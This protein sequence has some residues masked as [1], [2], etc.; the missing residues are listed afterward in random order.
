MGI[1]AQQTVID[2]LYRIQKAS[3][4]TATQSGKDA[5]KL[6]GAI[7]GLTKAVEQ[8]T[9]NPNQDMFNAMD[10]LNNLQTRAAASDPIASGLL[11]AFAQIAG[12]GQQAQ[13][14]VTNLYQLLNDNSREPW[15][16]KLL[17]E[18]HTQEVQN[19]RNKD[20]REVNAETRAV[21]AAAAK[22]T[23][24]VNAE[25][26][27]VN[28][29]AA[30]ETRDAAEHAATLGNLTDANTRDA[31]ADAA[32]MRQD[33][34]ESSARVSATNNDDL[35]AAARHA[36]EMTNLSNDDTRAAATHRAKEARDAAV[37]NQAMW[38]AYYARTQQQDKHN[39]EMAERPARFSNEMTELNRE[40]WQDDQTFMLQRRVYAGNINRVLGGL[41]PVAQMNVLNSYMNPGF[42]IN[43]AVAANPEFFKNATD[44]ATLHNAVS[45]S[46]INKMEAMQSAQRDLYLVQHLGYVSTM[47]PQDLGLFFGASRKAGMM[48]D[49]ASALQ[50]R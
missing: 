22:E 45:L 11:G 1:S 21:N 43:A 47:N 32:K 5:A 8:S 37:H 27:A 23:R 30:K 14:P 48:S 6:F 10:F 42:D 28:A 17:A 13:D 19:L 35:R 7:Q 31:A 40:R 34:A 3:Q 15:A 44:V 20:T 25:T 29:A 26:R 33:A 39:R 18:I 36:R 2:L 9:A 24:E 38:D 46:E 4:Q 16:T 50:Q 12:G 41:P 49:A